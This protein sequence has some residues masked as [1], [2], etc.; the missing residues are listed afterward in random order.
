M[1]TYSAPPSLVGDDASS[2]GVEDLYL[3]WRS[4]KQL[5]I[6]ARTRS[7]LRVGRTQYKLGHGMLLWDGAADGGTRGGYWTGAR[8][9]FEFAAIGRFKPGNH[10]FEAFYLD[11]DEMP[12]CD[13]DSKLWGLNYEYA[14]GEDTT[15]GAT[16]MKLVRGSRRGAAARRARCLQPAR[17]H[18]TVLRT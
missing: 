18:G 9:A 8:K 4:G 16:Y 13:S 5:R 14:F 2:F 3:G 1:R 11:K 12:E 15:L 6:S 10:T 7:T 17:L